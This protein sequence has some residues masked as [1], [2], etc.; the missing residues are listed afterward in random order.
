MD[1][2]G[3]A[4]CLRQGY[5][6]RQPLRQIFQPST[7]VSQFHR[8]MDLGLF[9]AQDLPFQCHTEQRAVMLTALIGRSRCGNDPPI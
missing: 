7:S 5:R 1:V 3:M 6:R 9:F 4:W 8:W 2:I